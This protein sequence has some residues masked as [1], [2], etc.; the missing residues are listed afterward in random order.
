MSI[1][2]VLSIIQKCC[3][4]IDVK[5]FYNKKSDSSRIILSCKPKLIRKD[6]NHNEYYK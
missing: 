2:T 3:I 5:H 1:K 4:T 6:L